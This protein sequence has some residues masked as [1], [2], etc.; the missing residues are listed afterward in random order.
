MYMRTDHKC[1]ILVRRESIKD[2]PYLIGFSSLEQL[3][4]SFSD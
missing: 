4:N 3:K 1:N 2:I